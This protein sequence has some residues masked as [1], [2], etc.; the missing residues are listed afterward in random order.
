MELLV[1]K[2]RLIRGSFGGLDSTINDLAMKIL[3]I[4]RDDTHVY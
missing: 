2:E 1:I 4:I 3:L